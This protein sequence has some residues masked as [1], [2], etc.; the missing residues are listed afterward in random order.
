MPLFHS[1]AVVAGWSPAVCGGATIV[2]EK[3]SASRF[4][5]DV[6]RYGVT[7]MNYVGKPLAY[8]LAT[9]ELP[10][11]ADNTLRVA[12]GNEASDRDIDEFMRRFGCD[13]WDGFGSTELAVIITREP[14]TPKGS[15]GKG[16]DGVAIYNSDTITEC[17]VAVFDENGALTNADEAT[18]ELVNTQGSGYFNG[19]YNDKSANDE[20][21][22][23]GMYW[24]GDLAYRDADG[25]IYLAGRT[26]DWM[27][28]DGEN[29]AAA[30][31]ERVLQRL[32]AINRVAVY[33][34]PDEQ[35]RRPGDGR[36]RAPGRR[37][38]VAGRARGVPRRPGRPVR[39]GLAALR[40]DRRRPAQH[41]DQQG[42]QARARGRGRQR[43]QRRALDPGGAR[44][45][46]RPSR[47]ACRSDCRMRANRGPRIGSLL[48]GFD[49]EGT[50]MAVTWDR[51]CQRPSQ[52]RPRRTRRS[53]PGRPGSGSS[54]GPGRS[55]A[56]SA[57]PCSGRCCRA[58][59]TCGRAGGSGTSSCC[60]SWPA[61]AWPP[62]TWAT[63]AARPTWRSTRRGCRWQR[64]VLGALFVVWLFVVATTYLMVRPLGM[65]RLEKGLGVL[66]VVLLCILGGLPAGTGGADRAQPGRPGQQRSST[67]RTPR[68]LPTTSPRR[69]R[70]AAGEQVNVLLLGGD[71]GVGRTGIRTD[72]VI[73]LSMNTQTGRSVMF[74]L[75]RNMMNAQFPEGSPLRTGLSGRFPQ[76]RRRPTR[77]TGC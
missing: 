62:T 29:L 64:V 57:S 38:P 8:V 74:S 70:G 53:A 36:D 7:Y 72:S 27:R 4:L 77:A 76:R 42:A 18:G 43:R 47:R 13:V 37:D 63:W 39:Q 21:M 50:R 69:T 30:P 1:N 46:V 48:P 40:P 54:G 16:F 67:A 5:P 11:D 41:G 59:G 24:S 25:W 31:I 22:R 52:R 66:V 3:F 32:E 49:R 23:H 58:P 28:V 14:G 71:G 35:R 19:Y 10:D 60:R 15:I 68:P 56:R 45:V 12:F 26:A 2:P 9:P 34:V 33:A 17:A 44:H 55:P 6:R 65:R 20:R 73:L 75:P 51:L 61:S